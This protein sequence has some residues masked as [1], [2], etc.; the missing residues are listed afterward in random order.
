MHSMD[1]DVIIGISII[2]EQGE[3]NE[4][5][6]NELELESALIALSAEPPDGITVSE[7]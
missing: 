2:L 5:L 4:N 7:L 3:N 6:S 1:F